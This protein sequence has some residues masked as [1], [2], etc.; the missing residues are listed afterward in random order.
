MA[1]S[2]NVDLKFRTEHDN[3]GKENY[4]RLLSVFHTGTDVKRSLLEQ[5]LREKHLNLLDWLT[6]V[7]Q[8]FLKFD[9]VKRA[10]KRSSTIQ[11]TDLELSTI[12]IL[13]KF[14]CFDMFW[15]LCLLNTRLEEILNS[16]KE[17]L[18]R[19]HHNSIRQ[20]G[21]PSFSTEQYTPNLTKNQWDIL[22]KSGE[23]SEIKGEGNVADISATKD[24]TLSSLD[25]PLNILLLYTVCPL[26][27]SVITVSN[28]QIQISKIAVLNSECKCFM[29]EK[30]W[31][32]IESHIISIA[33]HCKLSDYYKGK[34]ETTK[35]TFFNKTLSQ[36]NRKCILE[37]AFNNPDFIRNKQFCNRVRKELDL[38]TIDDNLNLAR[39]L[40]GKEIPILLVDGKYTKGAYPLSV[41]KNADKDLEVMKSV[42]TNQVME[43]DQNE[44][45]DEMQADDIQK[46]I[47]KHSHL[48]VVQLITSIAKDVLV[49]VLKVRLPGGNFGYA[50][51][52]MK[53][54]IL[55]QLNNHGRQLLYPDG[56]SYSGDLSDLDISL[57]YTIL[58]NINTIA[59]QL[60]GWGNMPK[61]NDRSLSAN[62]D[63]IRIFKNKYVSHCSYLSLD[64]QDFL[65]TWK[66][67]GQCIIQLGGDDYIRKIDSLLTTEINPVMEKELCNTIRRLKE[68]DRQNELNYDSLKEDINEI[69]QHLRMTNKSPTD[70]ATASNGSLGSVPLEFRIEGDNIP[71]VE[72]IKKRTNDLSSDDM[73][74]TF[75]KEGSIIIGLMVSPS[76]LYTVGNFLGMIDTLLSKLLQMYPHYGN[77]HTTRIVASV[78]FMDEQN[79]PIGFPMKQNLVST[80]ELQIMTDRYILMM[81]MEEHT[82]KLAR[83]I[84]MMRMEESRGKL[85]R[86]IMIMGM[87]ERR[88]KLDRDIRI[89]GMEERRRKLD[90]D[91]RIMEWKKEGENW[92][93]T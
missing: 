66:E 10:I 6:D 14:H 59:P 77:G 84:R 30:L 22:F 3:S 56:S 41:V 43:A 49:D 58:R 5:Y 12:D 37:D 31:N 18:L 55:P 2:N 23:S 11:L 69:K 65:Q 9:D 67:I 26:F 29:F 91:I 8:T 74:I 39:K 87:E 88:R 83:D 89:M 60:N 32:I 51:N 19:I 79:E 38:I 72:E 62:I 40:C 44:T 75:A 80:T 54:K 71:L 15:E 73:R 28:C 46:R 4:D 92:I 53:K 57:I 93:R 82:R 27:Q 64:E 20:H 47:N 25:K 36:E 13:L 17:E 50:F 68:A 76:A 63:R 61:D 81:T 45:E 33:A 90:R 48:K 70:T 34:C 1:E 24:I 52:G 35:Q 85:D 7:N 86:D 16:H 21:L 42:C 78:N